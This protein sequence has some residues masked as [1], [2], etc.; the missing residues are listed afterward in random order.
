M[1]DPLASVLRRVLFLRSLALLALMLLAETLAHTQ[2]VTVRR[3]LDSVSAGNL[4]Y[5]LRILESAGGHQSR[6]AYTPGN[7]TA[8]AYVRQTLSHLAGPIRVALDTFFVSVADTPYNRRPLRNVV[9]TL[10]GTI[11][12]TKQIILGAHLDCSASRMPSTVWPAQ[13]KNATV[14][15]AD[16]NAT[17]VAVILELARLLSDP[18][19]GCSNAYTIKFVAFNA[20]ESVP[21]Y[22]SRI[23]HPGSAWYAVRAKARGDQILGMMSIDM[24]GFNKSYSYTNV[25]ANSA[26]QTLG[27]SITTA[28]QTYGIGLLTNS[29][30]FASATFSDHN[31]FWTQGYPAICLIEYNPPWNSGT[32]YVAN[33]YYH[34]SYD[35]MG[36]V[37]IGLV[38]RVAQAVLGAT[39]SL[40]Q[41]T[42]TSAPDQPVTG[43]PSSFALY[44]N[45]PNPFNGVSNFEFALPA[46]GQGG[47]SEMSRVTL[48]VYDVLGREVATLV[49][50]ERLPGRYSIR[51]DATG[52]SNGMYLYCLTAGKNASVKKMMLLQ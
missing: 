3:L 33:P 17:G 16:D 30:P 25:V 26:S 1:T 4:S 28:N 36:T 32:Y 31:E 42:I 45:Y 50:G 5:H 22:G 2:N 15:G 46:L 43:L 8:V 37:N 21:P 39:V 9:A 52:L 38:R 13:W 34:T 40:A 18:S 19:F 12:T 14:P 44:Q 47:I 35:T 49:D 10:L 20:E 51:W 48:K 24:I 23:S 41:V 6:V 7:D 29:A 11:D 27:A